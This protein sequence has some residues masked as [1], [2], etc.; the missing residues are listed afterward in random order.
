[1]NLRLYCVSGD[2]DIKFPQ[3]KLKEAYEKAEEIIQ[4]D[5]V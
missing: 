5:F 4:R 3:A 1:M 2:I